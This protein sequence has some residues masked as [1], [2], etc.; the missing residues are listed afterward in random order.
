M[1]SP[2]IA[3][4]PDEPSNPKLQP[5]VPG[6]IE[7]QY[8]T[9]G[10]AYL[11]RREKRGHFVDT[12]PVVQYI[13]QYLGEPKGKSLIDVGCGGGD[14]LVKYKGYGFAEVRGIDPSEVMV[15]AAR[16]R[17]QDDAAVLQGKWADLSTLFKGEK[18]DVVVGRSSLHYEPD[19]DAAY[20]VI[21]EILKPGGLLIL[22]VP[23]PRKASIKTEHR[24]IV[25]KDGRKYV[26]DRILGSGVPITYPLHTMDDYVESETFKKFFELVN[27]KDFLKERDG[28]E[29]PDQ[30]GIVARRR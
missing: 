20:Q 1:R 27:R 21:A 13:R 2:K 22:I 5:E 3:M 28:V 10:A 14:E 30:L 6:L 18:K 19:L 11:E 15:K 8:D 7:T 17:V 23:D 24:R 4:Q 25:E 12:H 16:E 26:Q 9:I 29:E